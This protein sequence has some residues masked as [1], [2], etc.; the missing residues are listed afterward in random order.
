MN[1]AIRDLVRWARSQG[2]TVE[3][4]TNGYTRFYAPNG[5][6]IVRYPATPSN[7]FR[8]MKDLAVALRRNG[9]EIPPPSKAEQCRREREENR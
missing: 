2:W 4:D 8:R 6:Y 5:D 3:D 9:L 7:P 1:N